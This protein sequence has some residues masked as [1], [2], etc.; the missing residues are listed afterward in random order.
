MRKPKRA[1][2]V[3]PSKQELALDR[4][5]EAVLQR[6]ADKD[7][8]TEAARPETDLELSE[9][10]LPQPWCLP[11]DISQAIRRLIPVWHFEKYSLVYEEHGCFKCERKDVPHQSLGF[12]LRCYALYLTRLKAAIVKRAGEAAGRPST[13]K[14]K[15]ALTLKADSA[16]QI[17]AEITSGHAPATKP[18][19]RLGR[20]RL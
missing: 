11:R 10:V 8:A 13:G 14:W 16:R 12:C 2:E 9:S 5:T 6:I 17:L 19:K 7:A 4:L 1:I 20:P 18:T 3:L 15:A